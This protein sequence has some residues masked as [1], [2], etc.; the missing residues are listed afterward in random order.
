MGEWHP[1]GNPNAKGS[2]AVKAALKAHGYESKVK[3]QGN[4]MFVLLPAHVRKDPE[5][6]AHAHSL[7][8]QH[9]GRTDPR[10]KSQK[11]GAMS[12]KPGHDY[13]IG[14]LFEPQKE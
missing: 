8:E 3:M 1:Y 2:P 5:K 12:W 4:T 13:T 14:E 9:S 11:G 6:L 7:I 10:W